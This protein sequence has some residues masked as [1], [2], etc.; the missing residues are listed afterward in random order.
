MFQNKRLKEN[1]AGFYKR[2]LKYDL[3]LVKLANK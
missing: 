1:P 3:H 2:K